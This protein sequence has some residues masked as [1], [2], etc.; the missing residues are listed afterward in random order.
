MDD[1]ALLAKAHEIAELALAPYK[2]KV[3][4]RV[5]AEMRAALLDRLL[6]EP[7]TRELLRRSLADAKLKEST[8][9]PQQAEPL[10]RAVAS[11]KPGSRR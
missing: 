2:D 4:S 1:E 8:E 6:H 11:R 5:L 9:F 7:E 3:P 10:V